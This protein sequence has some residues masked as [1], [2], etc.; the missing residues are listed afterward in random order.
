MVGFIDI[1]TTMGTS[2][3]EHH[4][5][6][7]RHRFPRDATPWSRPG[8]MGEAALHIHRHRQADKYRNRGGL[9]ARLRGAG[10]DPG[11]IPY[12]CPSTG[13]GRTADRDQLLLRAAASASRWPSEFDCAAPYGAFD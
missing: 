3:P 7:A 2:P 11:W 8:A 10:A 5:V 6:N 4:P 13:Q 1:E 12:D 9:E